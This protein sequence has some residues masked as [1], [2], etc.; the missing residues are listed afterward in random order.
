LRLDG[1][2]VT[3]Q[4]MGGHQVLAD[5]DVDRLD[6]DRRVTDTVSAVVRVAVV[7]TESVVRGLGEDDEPVATSTQSDRPTAE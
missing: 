1:E 4:V 5:I 3:G 7:A 2:D 6:E